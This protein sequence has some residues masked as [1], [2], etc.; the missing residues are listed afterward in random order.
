[1]LFIPGRRLAIMLNGLVQRLIILQ[2]CEEVCQ[3]GAGRDP[4]LQTSLSRRHGG[5]NNDSRHASLHFYNKRFYEPNATSA[6]K[7]IFY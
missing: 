6:Y 4:G 3:E 5:R 7:K 2:I 1:M